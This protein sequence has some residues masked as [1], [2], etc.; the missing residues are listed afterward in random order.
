[1][2]K[3]RSKAEIAVDVDRALELDGLIKDYQEEL[4]GIKARLVEDGLDRPEEHQK[5]EEEEREGRQ[6]IAT[7]TNM[8]VPIVFTADN[9]IGS[10]TL[11]SDKLDGAKEIAGEHFGQFYKK[12]T[13]LE[14]VHEDGLE[15]RKRANE[16]LGDKAPKFVAACRDIKKDG[17][18]KS[19]KRVELDRAEK[20][21]E[22][23]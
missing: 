10:V 16:L 11:P 3:L 2:K 7:G 22:A 23:A 4:K 19:A 5:L 21:K 1:M 9:L 6:W 13:K 20:R 17:T 14:N 18:P 8:T 15:F 12:V